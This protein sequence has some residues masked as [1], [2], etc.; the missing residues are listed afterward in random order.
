MKRRSA[1]IKTIK[2]LAFAA[3]LFVF[4]FIGLLGW[5]RP[6]TSVIEKRELT[7]YPSLSWS[8]FWDGSYLNQISIWYS[9]T[10]PIREP[11]ISANQKLQGLYGFKGEQI[12]GT[13]GYSVADE[14][15]EIDENQAI[16]PSSLNG[17]P[18]LGIIDVR[19][20]IEEQM[21]KAQEAKLPDGT[22]TE[23]GEQLG[24]IYVTND[25]GYEMYYFNQSG[26]DAFATTIN[27]M[28]ANVKNMVDLYVLI[29]PTSAGVMLDDSVIE[30]M[31]GSDQLKALNYLY[32]KMDSGVKTVNCIERLR[33]HN[34][35]YVYFRTDHHWTQLGAYYAYM[36][37]CDVKGITPVP[38]EEYTEKMTFPGF[39]GTFCQ[40]VPTLAYNPDTVEAY[41]PHGT[42]D[43]KTVMGDGG[44]Y[45]W[46]IINDVSSY[47]ETEYYGTFAGG[48]QSF[49]SAHN[50]NITDGS[51]VMVIKDSFGNAFIPWLIDQYEYVYWVDVR[52]TSNTISQ[53]VRDC[54]IDDVIILMSIFSG[55]TETRLDALSQIGQ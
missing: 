30:D 18:T 25:A 53:M 40:L 24:N 51:A 13:E 10:Y 36:T 20:R 6:D 41:V 22:I 16:K 34:A 8:S 5:L 47:V 21:K 12:V 17:E 37:F 7:K 26:A 50:E 45:D 33:N 42:N 11:L 39:T 28:Y 29:V 48:D 46:Y 23:K 27:R 44:T 31:G 52:Y 55:T 4:F 1:L 14:I 35:E 54:D 9:D 3:V 43:M 19:G 38:L 15:P 32:R 49:S 2:T